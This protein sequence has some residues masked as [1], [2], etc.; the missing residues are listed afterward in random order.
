[1]KKPMKKIA[2]TI[3]D[4]AG[5]G[6]E[7]ALKVVSKPEFAACCELIGSRSAFA[8]IGQKLQLPVPSIIDPDPSLDTQILKAGQHTALSG[9]IAA[10]AIEYGIAGCLEGRYAALVTAPIS[11]TAIHA[12]GVHFPG[13]T[14]WCAAR[15]GLSEDAVTM[16]LTGK[17]LTVALATDHLSL[18]DVVKTLSPE[19]IIR[20]TRHLW[21]FL[22]RLHPR[23]LLALC[24][25]NPHAGE[26]GAF[27]D[28]ESRI[29]APALKTLLAEG[30]AI[31]GPLPPDTAFAPHNRRRY[32]G[33]VC[34]YHDQGLIP[35]KALCFEDGVNLT[36]G[37]PFIRTSP[38]HG[39]ASTLAWQGT[40]SS[41]SMEAALRL[42]IRLAKEAP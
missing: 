42:A 4:P 2:L 9:A 8:L 14:Q 5:V 37:L 13:H 22:R 38:D 23:P 20:T 27:G 11:K 33:H 29:L 1:M 24:A 15:A 34:C 16:C 10:A 3:G 30:I 39:T 31:E 25:L 28:E 21:Q 12:A 36:L 7:L 26:A 6:P 41:E 19:H 40:A 32:Q 35:F 18:A 17:E